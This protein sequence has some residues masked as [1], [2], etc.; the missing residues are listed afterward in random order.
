MLNPLLFSLALGAAAPVPCPVETVCITRDTD[1]YSFR[2]TYPMAAARVAGL[3]GLLRERATEAEAA[4]AEAAAE[5]DH[6]SRL[7]L[8]SSYRLDAELPEIVALTGTTDGYSGPR[9]RTVLFDPRSHERLDLVD[10]FHPETFDNFF[11]WSR[12][13]GIRAAQA[14]FCHALSEAVRA[15]RAGLQLRE[16][17]I[18]CPDV[19]DQEV[20]TIC[21][22]RGRILAMRAYVRPEDT[23]RVDPEAP[24]PYAVDFDMSAEMIGVM[25]TRYR[26]AFGLP[27]ETRGRRRRSCPAA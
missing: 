22:G 17:D 13:R 12:I 20:T 25:K 1:S 15:R 14:S 9:V 23:R 7:W 27:G 24:R 6:R 10:L 2:F 21:N 5:T 18:D 4:L 19:E 8:E 16:L 26:V 11:F 3:D